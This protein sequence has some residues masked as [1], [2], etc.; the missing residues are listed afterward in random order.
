[1]AIIVREGETDEQATLAYN[2][3]ML[4]RANPLE[5]PLQRPGAPWDAPF[6]VHHFCYED[7]LAWH[8]KVIPIP[9]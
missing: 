7:W 1:M 2:I 3:L 6:L 9:Q 5:H 8:S 4:H